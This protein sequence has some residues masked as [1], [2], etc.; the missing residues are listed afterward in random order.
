MVSKEALTGVWLAAQSPSG[1]SRERVK[2]KLKWHQGAVCSGTLPA[3]LCTFSS[4]SLMAAS[5]LPAG[6]GGQPSR[7]LLPAPT[8]LSQSEL[9][10]SQAK[11]ER[12]GLDLV[13]TLTN[14]P[15]PEVWC[16]VRQ[17]WLQAAG[18]PTVE[19]AQKSLSFDQ[20]TWTGSLEPL[21]IWGHVH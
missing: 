7:A 11:T 17:W 1:A 8:A 19:G 16:R 14:H 3:S 6:D 4:S 20:T 12:P 5:P 18:W 10:S 21:P 9:G 13:P 2:A 15:R